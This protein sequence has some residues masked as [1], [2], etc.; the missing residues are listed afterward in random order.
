MSRKCWRNIWRLFG[1][2][3]RAVR[4]LGA[5]DDCSRGEITTCLKLLTTEELRMCSNIILNFL[6][7]KRHIYRR[8][9]LWNNLRVCK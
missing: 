9:K 1:A 7:S 2:S 6:S 3:C 4:G 8:H 5:L